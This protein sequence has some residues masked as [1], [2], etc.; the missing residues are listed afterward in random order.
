MS[1]LHTYKVKIGLS[2]QLKKTY[3]ITFYYSLRFLR[4]KGYKR[5][6]YKQSLPRF[7]A[8]F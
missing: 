3:G 7:N 2:G 5:K 4:A 6:F 8:R 1:T